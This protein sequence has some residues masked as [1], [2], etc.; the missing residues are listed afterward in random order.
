ME[1][2][3]ARAGV[4]KVTLYKRFPDKRSLLRAVLQERR[5]RWVPP[6]PTSTDLEKRLKHYA[7]IILVGGISAEVR[8]FHYLVAS[9][10]PNHDEMAAREDVLGYN[11]MLQCLKEE[12]RSGSQK[13][14]IT[15]ASASTVAIAL[16][17]ML[18]GWFDHKPLNAS[19]ADATK[20]ARKAVELL[21]HGKT[22]W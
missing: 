15:S 17:A 18:S 9:A 16:M 19:R 10:W 21:I 8:A 6:P 12:I 13:L 5:T 2:I 3:A 20:F 7:A 22:A 1:M 11:H 4:T 14:G